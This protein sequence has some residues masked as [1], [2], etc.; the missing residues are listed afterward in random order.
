MTPGREATKG[1]RWRMT[2]QHFLQVLQNCLKHPV[3]ANDQT[4]L[5]MNLSLVEDSLRG[6]FPMGPFSVPGCLRLESQ[7]EPLLPGLGWWGEQHSPSAALRASRRL[8]GHTH[9]QLPG[10]WRRIWVEAREGISSEPRGD[11]EEGLSPTVRGREAK[12]LQAP[13]LALLSV[14]LVPSRV[15]PTISLEESFC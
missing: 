8:W 2:P 3:P 7:E 14:C 15:L 5:S 6:V 9:A 4:P 13:A 10:Q 11:C 12:T 1:N